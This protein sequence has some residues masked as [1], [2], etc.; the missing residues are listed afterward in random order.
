MGGKWVRKELDDWI[1]SLWDNGTRNAAEIGR[2]L[3]LTTQCVCDR[4]ERMSGK[5]VRELIRTGEK[6]RTR[7]RYSEPMRD[8]AFRLWNKGVRT[9]EI[10]ERV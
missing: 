6:I 10:S 7:S 9:R 2:R 8:E 3:G 4:L 1:V 5:R